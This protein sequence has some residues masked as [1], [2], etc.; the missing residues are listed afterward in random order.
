MMIVAVRDLD[1]RK[2]GSHAWLDA[3]IGEDN[4]RKALRR[5]HSS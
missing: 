2:R 5:T 3:G 1:G 4:A